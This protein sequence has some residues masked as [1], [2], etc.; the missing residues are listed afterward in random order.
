MVSL[1]FVLPRFAGPGDAIHHCLK[2]LQLRFLPES[3]T[4]LIESTQHM[5]RACGARARASGAH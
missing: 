5:S 1:I 4:V 2:I 3:R